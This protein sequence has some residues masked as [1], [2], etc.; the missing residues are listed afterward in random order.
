MTKEERTHGARAEELRRQ[1]AALRESPKDYEAWLES[2]SAKE[3]AAS[4][5]AGVKAAKLRDK[6]RLKEAGASKLARQVRSMERTIAAMEDHRAGLP[7]YARA[8]R[9]EA[10]SVI[11]MTKNSCALVR[12]EYFRVAELDPVLDRWP[13]ELSPR[14]FY[15]RGEG[16]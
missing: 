10:A 12:A 9:R 2:E 11:A 3:V 15:S 8:K 16:P 14:D 5:E 7:W 13:S 1:L 4:S 6:E